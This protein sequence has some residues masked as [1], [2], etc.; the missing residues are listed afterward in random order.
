MCANSTDM[1]DKTRYNRTILLRMVDFDRNLCC[2]STYL[3]TVIQFFKRMA[4][5]SAVISK[6]MC[7]SY[8]RTYDGITLHT[9]LIA[10]KA[11]L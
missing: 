6:K 3:C 1:C 5:I 9:E 10:Y 8:V 2:I 7:L 4:W 11:D